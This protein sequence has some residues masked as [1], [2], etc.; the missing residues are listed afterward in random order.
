ML[1]QSRILLKDSGNFPCIFSTKD[2][3]LKTIRIGVSLHG[4]TSKRDST[5]H[6]P[7]FT[8]IRPNRIPVKK[9]KRTV[10]RHFEMLVD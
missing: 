3:G 10:A 2:F 1:F 8:C 7:V 5:W 9:I 4:V 6:S